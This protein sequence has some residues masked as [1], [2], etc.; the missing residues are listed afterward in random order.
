MTK[1]P[2]VLPAVDLRPQSVLLTFF[3]DFVLDEGS[4]VPA[5][6]VLSVLESVGVGDHAARATLNR[7]V[8]R[9]LLE[10]TSAGRQAYFGLTPFGRTT[11]IDGRSRAQGHGDGAAK[12]DGRW[13][14]VSFS[15][16]DEAH[17]SRHELRARLSWAGFGLVQSGLWA[18]PRVV[19][20]VD[21]LDDLD[22]VGSVKAFVGAPVEPT[23]A[24]ELV[25][26]AFDLDEIGGRYAGFLDRWRRVDA[27][28]AAD[29]PDPLACRVLLSSDWIQVIRDDPRLP[30]V[31][32]GD[33][34]PGGSARDLY[35]RLDRALKRPADR[36]A[37]ARLQRVSVVD[38]D[39]VRDS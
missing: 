4:A 25:R 2:L 21:L 28:D 29:V 19:D 8:K 39:V 26:S 36:A 5:S 22:T 1:G 33:D 16:P 31:F 23:D 10:R 11:V 27:A 18:A 32:L 7:M 38:G 37:A 13:T 6:S 3:G 24:A 20:V 34:W 9:G 17:R 35:R 15:F 30:A 12:W 14:F